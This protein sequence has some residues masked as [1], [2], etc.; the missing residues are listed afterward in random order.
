[1]SA[2]GLPISKLNPAKKIANQKYED[3]IYIN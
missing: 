3:I 1:M 2:N